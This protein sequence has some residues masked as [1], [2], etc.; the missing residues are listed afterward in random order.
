MFDPTLPVQTRGGRPARIIATD[1]KGLYPIIALIANTDGTE[2]LRR[3]AET[4]KDLYAADETPHDLVN[5]PPPEVVRYIN[6][7]HAY[8]T[9]EGARKSSKFAW[10]ILKVVRRAD[11]LVSAEIVATGE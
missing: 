1:A 4:G 7:G 2:R 11:E 5:V 9:V 6:M 3:V 8:E 10:P